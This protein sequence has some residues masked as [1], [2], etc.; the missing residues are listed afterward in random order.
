MVAKPEP[1]RVSALAQKTTAK[2]ISIEPAAPGAS[3]P[4]TEPKPIPVAKT[5][6]LAEPVV[7][8][9]QLKPPPAAEALFTT[10]ED[11]K[12]LFDK[13][14]ALFVDSRTH[15]D[16]KVEH[17]PGAVSLYHGSVDKLYKQVLG[18]VPKNRT[19]ITYCSDPECKEATKVA[20]ELVK[21][22]HSKVFILLEGL[23][24]WVDAGYKTVKEEESVGG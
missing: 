3:K 12:L 22:G 18:S 13:G 23:P 9:E 6:K 11:A 17:V 14:S 21:R 16:F 19:I 5:V 4:E 8:K 15:E 24:G 7:K 10:L 20:D 1:V 2:N